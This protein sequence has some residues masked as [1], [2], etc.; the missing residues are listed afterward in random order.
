MLNL[1]KN[2]KLKRE[3]LGLSQDELARLTGYTSRSSVAKIEKGIVDLPQTKIE[4]FAKALKTT[5]SELMGWA[6]ESKSQSQNSSIPTAENIFPMPKTKRVPLIG[7]IAC[8]APIYA[9]ENF[10]DMLPVPD[11]INADFCLRCQGDSMID[12]RINDGD[13]VYIRAQPI[14]DNGDIAAVLIGDEATLKR[15]YV[16]P[17]KLVL[18]A[19]NS[20]YEPLIYVGEEVEYVRIL[21]KATHFTSEI[22]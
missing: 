6:E 7:T 10:E 2:I 16:Y 19:A 22:I 9:D 18:Q 14:V 21:G 4:L 12:A 1:Y 13:V 8:G 15:V 3:E 17:N 20:T 11:Y 5:P